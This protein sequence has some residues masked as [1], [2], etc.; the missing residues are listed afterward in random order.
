MDRLWEFLHMGI[1]GK[2][3]IIWFIPPQLF[4]QKKVF[5]KFIKLVS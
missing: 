3:E 4:D 2:L 5:N 1:E